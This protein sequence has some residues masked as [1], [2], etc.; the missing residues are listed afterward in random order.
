MSI[1]Y[2]RSEIRKGK[3]AYA[4]SPVSYTHLKLESELGWK[5]KYN[6]DTGIQQ[7]IE[8]Y[9]HNREW[10]ENILSGEYQNYFDKMYNF[11]SLDKI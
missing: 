10:W 6:F 9:L 11:K 4:I 1:K 8:W 5:P 3:S 7:T 2:I